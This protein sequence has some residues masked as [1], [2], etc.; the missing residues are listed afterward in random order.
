MHF[1]EVHLCAA[2]IEAWWRLGTANPGTSR[3]A[4]ASGVRND[5]APAIWAQE[6]SH[7]GLASSGPADLSSEL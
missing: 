1:A 5:D 6:P 3:R 7:A 4:I 2:V